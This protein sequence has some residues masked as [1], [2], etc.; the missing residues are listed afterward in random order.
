[1]NQDDLK[2][3]SMRREKD[4]LR[5]PVCGMVIDA[6]ENIVVYIQMH[7]AFCSLQCKERAT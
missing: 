6:S 7:F 2:I 3:K 5:D 4:S 1:M